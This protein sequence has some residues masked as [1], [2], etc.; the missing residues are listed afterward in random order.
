MV[1]ARFQTATATDKLPA[2]VIDPY[3]TP[4]CRFTGINVLFSVSLGGHSGEAVIFIFTQTNYLG[5]GSRNRELAH[6]YME[7]RTI[8]Q[9]LSKLTKGPPL[10]SKKLVPTF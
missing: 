4:A 1:N 5:L 10:V 7:R 6:E 3:R 9:S 2:P 8:W